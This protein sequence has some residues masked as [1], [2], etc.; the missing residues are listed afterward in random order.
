MEITLEK[1]ELVRDRTGV[2]Y[3]EAKDA[4][5][6]CDG[7]IVDAIISLEKVVDGTEAPKTKSVGETKDAIL[8]KIKEIVA[9]GNVSKI[10]I[11]K[12]DKTILNMPLTAGIVGT[13]IAPWGIIAG[14][15]AAFGTKCKIEFLKD[16]GSMVDLSGKA[17][18]AFDTAKEKGQEVYKTVREKA[19]G[20]MDELKEKGKEFYTNV[21]EKAPGSVDELKAKG[22]ELYANVKE[23]APGSVDEL[24]TKGGEALNK[25]KEK[26]R[27]GVDE[28]EDLNFDDIKDEL[29]DV[30]ED[31]EEKIEE[32]VEE[33]KE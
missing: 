7:N 4:L 27:R 6:A 18:G 17:T 26:I 2:S 3:K 13:I 5:E 8:G 16:D 22:K 11:T 19:P 15:I 29:S 20:S 9:K 30:I 10:I 24:K 25:A 31:A 28:I 32:V 23:K 33:V 12:E 14:V 21:K 1:I